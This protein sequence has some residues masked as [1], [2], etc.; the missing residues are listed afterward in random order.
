MGGPRL[1]VAAFL[2]LVIVAAGGWVAV[3]AKRATAAPSP[4]AAH[5]MPAVRRS[6]DPFQ[7]WSITEQFA[8]QSVLVVQVETR[9][10]TDALAI[11]REIATP[12]Q[13]RYTEIM[14]YFHRPGRPD[15]L[16]PR[17]VQWTRATGFVETDLEA[18]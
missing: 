18:Q 12:L 2:L 6:A 15:T 16:P 5:H 7:R 8:A 14:M 4:V 1:V 11:A 17:R 13:D 9:Q 10:L 3:R